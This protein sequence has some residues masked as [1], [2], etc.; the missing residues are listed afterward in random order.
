MIKKK[1]KKVF[2]LL[3][4]AGLIGILSIPTV[5]QTPSI[6][7]QNIQSKVV[8]QKSVIEEQAIMLP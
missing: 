4:I 1:K 8:E 3:G 2:T 5:T 7:E 6:P